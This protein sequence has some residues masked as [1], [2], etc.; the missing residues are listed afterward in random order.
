MAMP[1]EPGD[2]RAGQRTQWNTA[3]AAWRKWA[4]L[5]NKGA[6][7][8]SER[9]VELAAIQPRHRVLDVA[10]GFGEPALTA[11]RR[12]SPEGEV[13]ATDISA[14]M[15]AFGRERAAEEGLENIRF[16]ERDAASLEFPER[17]F[18]AALS[19]WGI[20]FE[21]EPERAAARIRAFLKPGARIAIASWA[22]IEQVPI[23]GLSMGTVMKHL[24][25]PPPPA[26]TPGPLARPTSEA[27]AGLL[28]GGGFSNVQVEG[29]DVVMEYAS[30]KEFVTSSLELAPPLAALLA[31]QPPDVQDEAREAMT[32]A[33]RER[34]G[35]DGPFRLSNNALLAVGEA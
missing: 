12:V 6:A 22:T 33:A 26:G 11:A 29:I 35:G 19:R 31:Q 2:F 24:Q 1:N 14:E 7:P 20:I 16:V 15:L 8:V 28:E 32:Q 21:P 34:A 30:P 27:I 3:A 25:V 4:P 10:A 23:F 9:L 5:I 13:V 18:D 17:S